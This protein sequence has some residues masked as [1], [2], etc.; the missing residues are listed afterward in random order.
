MARLITSGFE[1]GLTSTVDANA[2]DGYVSAGTIGTNISRYTTDKRSGAA[3]LRVNPASVAVVTNQFTVASVLDRSYWLRF[4]LKV[5]TLP[6]TSWNILAWMDTATPRNNIL[7]QDDGFMRN[8]AG[9]NSVQVNDGNWHRVELFIKASAT[10]ANRA[11]A[12]RVDGNTIGSGTGQ[13]TETAVFSGFVLGLVGPT[14]TTADLLF[15]DV[16]LNDDQGTFQNTWPGDGNIVLLRPTA[17]S[18]VGTG[19][20]LGT[21]TAISGNTGKTAVANTPPIGVADLTAGS[22]NKQ[23]RNATSNANVNYDAT[24]TTY[25]AAGVGTFDTVNVVVPLISTAAPVVT[26]AKAGTFGVVSNPAITSIA[27]GA[28]GTAGAFWSGVAGG[29][30]PTGWKFTQGTITYAPAVTKG[31]APV[32]RVTQ[33]TSS[34]RIAV[35]CFMG[36]YVD[37]TPGT[38]PKSLVTNPA[39]RQQVARLSRWY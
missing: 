6:A 25:T 38:A 5:L 15:E 8:L 19:W 11:W 23:I 20:T 27:L 2:P 17:D 24:M 32:M 4:Y 34:T 26:S 35:V 28:G 3:C 10:Q 37:F 33:V 31:T 1:V 16:A 18:A 7:L 36:M 13:L 30:W 39:R 12:F 14:G 21:G 22:D 29:T 9:S